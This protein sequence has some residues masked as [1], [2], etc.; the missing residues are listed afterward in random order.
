LYFCSRGT[1]GKKRGDKTREKR[2]GMG[3]NHGGCGNVFVSV[4]GNVIVTEKK[5]ETRPPRSGGEGRGGGG[6]ISGVVETDNNDTRPPR[7]HTRGS[8]KKEKTKLR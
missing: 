7:Q 1:L 5:T 4:D 6:V 2:W 8:K 3:I